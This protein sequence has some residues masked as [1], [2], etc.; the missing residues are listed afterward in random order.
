MLVGGATRTTGAMVADCTGEAC[1][2]HTETGLVCEVQ[3]WGK[4]GVGGVADIQGCGGG[5][6]ALAAV[7]ESSPAQPP[8]SVTTCVDK[9]WV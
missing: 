4:A 1:E 9:S 7:A 3:A 8:D 2:V 5:S 6:A